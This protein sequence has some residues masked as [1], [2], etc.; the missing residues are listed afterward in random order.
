MNQEFVLGKLADL[1]EWDN[2]T[3]RGEFAWLRLMSRMKYDG[4]P[5]F[6]AGMRFIESLTDWLQQFKPAHRVT[7]YKFVRENLVFVGTAEMRHLVELLYPETVQPRLLKRVADLRGIPQYQVWADP[8]ATALYQKLLKK[9]LFIELSDGGRIDIFRRANPGVIKNEQVVTAPQINATKWDDL[10]KKLRKATGDVNDRFAFVFLVDDFTASGTTLLRLEEDAWDGKLLRFWNDIKTAVIPKY[11][12]DDWTLCVH[13]YLA[14]ELAVK[15]V[16]ERDEAA[17]GELGADGWFRQKIEM[18]YGMRIPAE[19]GITPQSH[20]DFAAIVQEYYDNSIE[21][22]HMRKGGN[23]ARF[24]FGGCGLP[25]ILEHNTPNNA[26]ALLWA[27]TDGKE[28]QHPMR[29]LFR[30]RQRHS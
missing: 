1:M 10:L 24:G 12:E 19:V 27:E 7:A 8:E 6:L 9:T 13:H 22:E 21:S 20:E 4:Y 29:P 16:E 11:F 26:I 30:R 23:D 15:T 2:E 17:R 14:T 18:S 25:L 3:A 5:E 28:G